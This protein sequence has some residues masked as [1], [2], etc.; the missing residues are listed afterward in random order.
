MRTYSQLATQS[1]DLMEVDGSL[2]E[3]G[4]KLLPFRTLR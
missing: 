2:F 1:P 3:E 4:E